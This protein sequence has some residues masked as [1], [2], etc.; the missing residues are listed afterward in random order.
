MGVT[1]AAA[2]AAAWEAADLAAVGACEPNA[3]ASAGK[4]AEDVVIFL[5]AEPSFMSW[6]FSLPSD[7][8]FTDTAWSAVVPGPSAWSDNDALTVCDRRREARAPL[9]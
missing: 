3:A 4:A 8:C 7:S 5:L 1:A 2:A 6:R 9:L